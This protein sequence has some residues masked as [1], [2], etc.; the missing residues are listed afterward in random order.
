[1]KKSLLFCFALPL[2]LSGCSCSSGDGVV[3]TATP[4][5]GLTK[6]KKIESI[7]SINLSYP[8]GADIPYI[9]LSEGFSLLAY[10]RQNMQGDADATYTAK[11]SATHSMITD[12][13]GLTCEVDTDKQTITIAEFDRFLYGNSIDT[14]PLSPAPSRPSAIKPLPAAMPCPMPISVRTSRR[15]GKWP[16]AGIVP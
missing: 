14:D 11:F 4:L 9:N 3:Y 6:D 2:L 13:R 16:L 7:T 15:L 12:E 1:M 10:L 8:Y 5:L